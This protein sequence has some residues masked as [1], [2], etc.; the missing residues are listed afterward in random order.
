MGRIIGSII[1]SVVLFSAHIAIAK[2]DG[3][4][5]FQQELCEGMLGHT[6]I[7]REQLQFD[8]SRG[9]GSRGFLG[10]YPEATAENMR[11]AFSQG[12]MY[13][14]HSIAVRRNALEA[15]A[16]DANFDG[17]A[18]ILYFISPIDVSDLN[19]DSDPQVVQERFRQIFETSEIVYFEG[20][21]PGR[22]MFR[23][24]PDVAKRLIHPQA[25]NFF[26]KDDRGPRFTQSG[27]TFPSIRGVL[28]YENVFA[29]NSNTIKNIIKQARSLEKK[30]Y[31]I[32][33]NTNFRE[34]LEKARYQVRLEHEDGKLK[35]ISEGSRYMKDPEFNSA[36]E[37]FAQG[38][39]VSVEVRDANNRLLAGVIG[40]HHK[41]VWAFDT[42]FYDFVDREDGSRIFT[43]Q[44]LTAMDDAR[45]A[46]SLIDY[47][48]IAVL[49]ALLRLHDHGID[50]SDA[51]MVTHFTAALKGQ[52]IPAQDFLKHIRELS[53]RPTIEVD[54]KPFSFVNR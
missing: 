6:L 10:S 48:K 49:A 53:S 21:H 8:Q 50:L 40:Q 11:L 16:H 18:K 22:K 30:G 19:D 4:T 23:I 15:A 43:S 9:I 42:I 25:I 45:Q 3:E 37:G 14:G 54:L 39:H 28:T 44:E 33:F 29:S 24:S 36:L 41:N 27:W 35:A 47:A 12:V 52:Y 7:N 26:T 38:S 5:R 34:A 32:T 31:T 20:D 46:K 2:T 17:L 1:V 51:G 13:W